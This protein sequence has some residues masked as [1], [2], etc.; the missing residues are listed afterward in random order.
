MRG[1][2]G[3]IGIFLLP[4]LFSLWGSAIPVWADAYSFIY[5]PGIPGSAHDPA[6]RNWIEVVSCDWGSVPPPRG[7]MLPMNRNGRAGKLHFGDFSFVKKVDRSSRMLAQCCQSKVQLSH[8]RI[9]LSGSGM[10]NFRY[11][12]LRKVKIL[13]VKQG[14]KDPNGDRTE[15]VTVGFK[16]VEYQ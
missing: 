8:I 15:V 5:V 1:L 13:S 11:L 12:V 14:E 2:R 10:G 16:Q 3:T 7:S 9:E 4:V 6:H